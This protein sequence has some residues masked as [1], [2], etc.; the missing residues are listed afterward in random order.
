[1]VNGKVID[2]NNIGNS[3]GDKVVLI[4]DGIVK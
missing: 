4:V 3:D 2:Q 1:M